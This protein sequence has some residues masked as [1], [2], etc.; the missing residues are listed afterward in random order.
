M[1]LQQKFSYMHSFSKLEAPS[2]LFSVLRLLLV[3]PCQEQK[4]MDG[5]NRYCVGF[6]GQHRKRWIPLTVLRMR[7]RELPRL[8]GYFTRWR[9]HSLQAWMTRQYPV[10]KGIPLAINQSINHSKDTASNWQQIYL[11]PM[12][13]WVG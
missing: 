11:R 12:G 4:H 5:A 8:P 6:Q 10:T 1:N 13:V 2:Y 7:E 9:C 3:I